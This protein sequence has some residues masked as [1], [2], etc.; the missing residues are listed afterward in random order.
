MLQPVASFEISF[1]AQLS[2]LLVELMLQL[3]T[4]RGI[5]LKKPIVVDEY[6]NVELSAVS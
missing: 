5:L 4:G 6:I 2:I 1:P 3:T